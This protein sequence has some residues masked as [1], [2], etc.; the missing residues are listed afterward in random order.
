MCQRD[1]WIYLGFTD[2]SE[3]SLNLLIRP[4]KNIYGNPWLRGL[5]T[6]NARKKI[7]AR[8]C[9]ELFLMR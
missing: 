2:E 4:R 3:L 1:V 8:P 7:K 9:G 5:S 6:L